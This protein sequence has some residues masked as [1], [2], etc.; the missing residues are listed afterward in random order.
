MAA[1]DKVMLDLNLDPMSVLRISRDVN[2]SDV[3]YTLAQ[4][5]ICAHQQFPTLT[6]LDV[7]N[8][9]RDA[10]IVALFDY[11]FYDNE[12]ETYTKEV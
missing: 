12:S 6:A 10:I 8:K 4:T 3:L 11:K 1:I 7:I 5:L 2:V 9:A